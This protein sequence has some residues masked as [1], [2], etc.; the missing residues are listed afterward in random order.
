[1][2]KVIVISAWAMLNVII[3]ISMLRLLDMFNYYRDAY[4]LAMLGESLRTYWGDYLYAAD[5]TLGSFPNYARMRLFFEKYPNIVG[6]H[7]FSPNATNTFELSIAILPSSQHP[8]IGVIRNYG[9]VYVAKLGS[10][11]YYELQNELLQNGASNVTIFTKQQLLESL[12]A[13]ENK[14]K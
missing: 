14:P 3:L 11:E 6:F 1:M 9:G 5:T 7:D 12:D 4:N 10:K 8:Y 13:L 2:K